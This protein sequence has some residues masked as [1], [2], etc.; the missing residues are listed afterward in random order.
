MIL[1][2][3]QAIPRTDEEPPTNPQNA[4]VA[5][6]LKFEIADS[7][8]KRGEPLSRGPPRRVGVRVPSRADRLNSKARSVGDFAFYG[9]WKD[10]TD[11]RDSAEYISNLPRNLGG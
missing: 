6:P 11:I 5:T 9:M 8:F 2:S 7:G 3:T 1:T 10:R 4:Y